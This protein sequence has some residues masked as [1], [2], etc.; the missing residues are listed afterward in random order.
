MKNTP[1]VDDADLTS[2]LALCFYEF[3]SG[4]FDPVKTKVNDQQNARI[5]HLATTNS[6][7]KFP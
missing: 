7:S 6:H 2:V 4:S 1:P 3:K 5:H